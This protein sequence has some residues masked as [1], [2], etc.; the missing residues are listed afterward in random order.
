LGAILTGTRTAIVEAAAAATPLAFVYFSGWAY[1]SAYLGKFDIDATQVDVSLATVLVYAFVPL[2]SW[3]VLIAIAIIAV[4]YL[5][6]VFVRSLMK[7][8]RRAGLVLMLAALIGLLFVVRDSAYAAASEMADLVWL[9][10]KSI[11]NPVIKPPE[12]S[13]QAYEE[14]ARCR[15]T[16]RLRQILG[17]TS[18][19]YLLCRNDVLPCWH[20]VLFAVRN[21]GTIAYSAE[22]RRNNDGPMASC[23]I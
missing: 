3:P 14:Y 11:T 13:D 23:K 6:S 16:R 1:L 7:F 21:D 5:L 10:Q 2:N 9:G 8:S 12:K 4:L 19:M 18:T 17:T 22:R 20:G 15:D